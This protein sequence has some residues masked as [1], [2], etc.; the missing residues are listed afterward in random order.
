MQAIACNIPSGARAACASTQVKARSSYAEGALG[1]V[2]AK[3]K[4]CKF[5]S[6]G[7]CPRDRN[8]KFAHGEAELQAVPDLA[9]TKMCPS[10]RKYGHCRRGASCTYAHNKD[11]LRSIVEVVP[12]PAAAAALVA[13]WQQKSDKLS[14]LSTDD[15][16]GADSEACSFGRVT[17]TVSDDFGYLSPGRNKSPTRSPEALSTD[18]LVVQASFLDAADG[19]KEGSRLFHTPT[20]MPLA[21]RNTF[22]DVE[23][24]ARPGAARRCSS[25]GPRFA[26]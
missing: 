1:S 21:I 25:A 17:P 19:M 18:V 26:C 13:A 7:G 15:S 22:I 16:D 8:C 2:C 9:R 23:D 10:L 14:E 24:T 6:N 4:L 11:E 3:T 5:F 12:K 20:G